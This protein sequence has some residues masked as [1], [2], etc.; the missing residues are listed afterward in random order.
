M[1][2]AHLADLHL[3]YRAF[4]SSRGGKNVREM[5][6]AR[7]FLLAVE[8]L[9]RIR[10]DAVII[11]G[12][13][14]HRSS[15]P[16]SALVTFA[17]GLTTLRDNLGHV[18]ILVVAGGHDTPFRAGDSSALSAFGS[19]P[20]V[21]L[22]YR[23]AA[24]VHMAER[25]VRFV[26]LPHDAGSTHVSPRVEPD[27]RVGWNVLV[28]RARATAQVP[29]SARK[30]L[31]TGV[32]GPDPGLLEGWDYVALG[33]CHQFRQVDRR[34]YFSGSLERI[35][36]D[37]WAEAGLDK[38]F[39]TY[40]LTREAA[41]FHPIPGRPVVELAPIRAVRADPATVSRRIREA[42]EAVPGGVDDKI[43][44]LRI[45][46][47]PPSRWGILEP[48]V[49]L[50]LRRRALHVRVEAVGET[51]TED[52]ADELAGSSD[53]SLEDRLRARM[54][55]EGQALLD[56][57]LL[58]ELDPS[59][60]GVSAEAELGATDRAWPRGLQL[61][62]L[63][64]PRARRVLVEALLGGTLLPPGEMAL[65][66]REARDHEEA[67]EPGVSQEGGEGS[68]RDA[69]LEGVGVRVR[70]P[71]HD[72]V[73]AGVPAGDVD[74]LLRLGVGY[75]S[76]LRGGDRLRALA[77]RALDGAGLA[78]ALSEAMPEMRAILS[79]SHQDVSGIEERLQQLRADAAEAAGDLA[80]RTMEWLRERQDAE[81]HLQAY[82]DR[83]RELRARFTELENSGPDSLCPSC[84]APL[85]ERWRDAM[86][87]LQDEWEAV[88]Q[89]GKWWKRRREQLELKPREL[90]E[91]ES[92]SV[93]LHAQVEGAAE[94]LGR[95]QVRQ[96]EGFILAP[97]AGEQGG[98]SAELK[99]AGEPLQRVGEAGE[100]VAELTGL[101]EMLEAVQGA[102]ADLD[103]ETRSEVLELAGT[104]LGRMTGGN[105]WGLRLS[106]G[107]LVP[108]GQGDP[109]SFEVEEDRW[110]AFLAL[111]LALA[112][113]AAYRG[114]R[115]PGIILGEELDR[116]DE[117]A[118]S[119][120]T[121]FLRDLLRWTDTVLVLTDG[122]VLHSLPEAW[123]GVHEA[124]IPR[125]GDVPHVRKV[126]RQVPEIH[127]GVLPD[128]G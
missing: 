119:G 108:L 9:V 19:S 100:T 45:G 59:E 77:G 12:D 33:G 67:G 96:E 125:G 99:V 43:V 41:S 106:G 63:E 68:S 126:E 34:A 10:P 79:P 73:V 71:H 72:S 61:V 25:D 123:E 113:A 107:R 112:R 122:T 115:F 36:T 51:E 37:P 128:T 103:R 102:R 114:S 93:W 55:P 7:A 97:G 13:V 5:D 124:W 50:D 23:K 47:L 46:G 69:L 39:L 2:L 91:L 92:R 83:A 21:H 32:T 60:G 42:V 44:R 22:A 95:E 20:Y 70:R 110:A 105:L 127:L 80:F 8:E 14:F 111:R 66:D 94:Q 16:P 109:A 65:A 29:L 24:E 85:G 57:A 58:A 26:L 4:A 6:V 120:C 30:T 1:I 75:V 48:E 118:R 88:V 56:A 84:G 11:A 89:D 53:A 87:G 64:N 52:H 86:G 78:P 17:R 27:P 3:G 121:P 40:D 76:R 104:L 54:G 15:P 28:C 38:G 98:P 82:R 35:G 62:V 31:A 81:T 18:P 101:T 117:D 49:F 90:Q 74:L 116:L